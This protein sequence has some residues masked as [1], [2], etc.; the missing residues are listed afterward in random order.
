[1]NFSE[2]RLNLFV[3]AESTGLLLEDQVV[4][5]TAGGE[6]PDSLLVF[7]AIGVSVEMARPF[8]AFLFEHLDQEEE[9]LDPFG[10]EAKVLI[11]A[12]AF[13]IVQVDVE[14]FARFERL[15]GHMIEVQSR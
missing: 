5:H 10:A 2:Q 1:M 9:V 7:A 13:L 6:I 3:F 12:R 4:S 11:E 15:R 8:V 14:E